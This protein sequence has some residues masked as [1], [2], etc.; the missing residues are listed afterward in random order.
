MVDAE[1]FDIAVAFASAEE[2]AKPIEA[3]D[4]VSASNFF[5]IF[6]PFLS[7]NIRAQPVTHPSRLVGEMPY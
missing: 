6:F 7:K 2:A 1:A 4:N 3:N 5:M